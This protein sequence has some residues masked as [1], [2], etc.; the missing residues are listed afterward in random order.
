MPLSKEIL[1]KFADLAGLEVRRKPLG[2]NDW[3]SLPKAR[4]AGLIIEFVGPQGIGKTTLHSTVFERVREHWFSRRALQGRFPLSKASAHI[5]ALHNDVLFRRMD[6]LENSNL[7]AWRRIQRAE[8]MARVA[9][10]S[11]LLSGS[12]FP[13]GFMFEEGLFKNFPQEILDIEAQAAKE[14]WSNRIFIFLRARDPGVVVSRWLARSAERG[15]VLEYRH[16]VNEEVR[17][18]VENES[19]LYDRLMRRAKSLGRP[20]LTLDAEDSVQHNAR[21][22]LDFEREIGRQ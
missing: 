17:N 8:Q 15:H 19:V 9:K 4:T 1:K 18:R 2:R 16:S 12:D 3:G 20:V 10:E 14:L 22:I 11:L 7:T 13:R 6:R 21:M 5:A